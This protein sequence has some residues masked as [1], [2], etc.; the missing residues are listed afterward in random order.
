MLLGC[1]LASAAPQRPTL[2]VAAMLPDRKQNAQ[3][4]QVTAAST[5]GCGAICRRLGD[6]THLKKTHCCSRHGG[7]EQQPNVLSLL[8]SWRLRA[9]QQISCLPRCSTVV[10]DLVS[11][12]RTHSTY[13]GEAASRC[14]LDM[15]MLVCSLLVPPS[16]KR[17]ISS[18]TGVT[19]SL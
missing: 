11:F 6:S 18:L 14:T 5:L 4:L 19:P 12:D 15:D 9:C 16:V 10:F 7:R 13:A 3:I 1:R 8:Q 2:S 17:R